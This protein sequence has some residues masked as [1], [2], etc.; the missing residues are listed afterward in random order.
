MLPD[1]AAAAVRFRKRYRHR[2]AVMALRKQFRR[3]K[4]FPHL[5]LP[6]ILEKTQYI[7][8]RKDYS[9]KDSRAEKL[10]SSPSGRR[11]TSAGPGTRR[12]GHSSG[13]C[14]AKS[15]ISSSAPLPA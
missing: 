6:A 2:K 7:K 10:T 13:F 8:V 5:A 15:K 9:D 11:Q 4:P 3:A 12:F 1:R 14:G